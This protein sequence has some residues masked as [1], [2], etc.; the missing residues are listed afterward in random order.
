MDTREFQTR[1][2]K[3]ELRYFET[4]EAAMKYSQKNTDVWKI[5]FPVSTG[6]RVRLVKFEM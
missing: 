6:E 3:G 1:T 5:S 4:L 2:E